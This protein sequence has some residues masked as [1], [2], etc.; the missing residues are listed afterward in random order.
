M[1]TRD[2]A[3]SFHVPGQDSYDTSV[4]TG[5]SFGQPAARHNLLTWVPQHGFLAVGSMSSYGM[6]EFRSR[7]SEILRRVDAGE[8]VV[9]TRRGRPRAKLMPLRQLA[10]TKLSLGTLRGTM[11]GLPDATYEDFRQMKGMW[12]R[13]SLQQA[14]D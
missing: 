3:D 14:P 1:D 10:D 7:L 2:R 12:G 4:G 9:I 6:R 5:R 13:R 8:A 11:T